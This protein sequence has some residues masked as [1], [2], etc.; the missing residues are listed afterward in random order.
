MQ[1]DEWWLSPPPKPVDETPT[2]EAAYWQLGVL[3]AL[4]AAGDVLMWGVVPGLSLTV[5]AGLC[6]VA[7]MLAWPHKLSRR[8]VFLSS[9]IAVLSILPIV[10]LVQ[11]LS[12]MILMTGLPISLAVLAGRPASGSVRFWWTAPLFSIRD[13]LH[14]IAA[15]NSRS[16]PLKDGDGWGRHLALGWGLPLGV[17]LVFAVLLISANPIL[18]DFIRNMSRSVMELPDAL[19]MLLWSVMACLIWPVLSLSRYARLMAP[20]AKSPK[21]GPRQISRFVNAKSVT[22]SLVLFNL[23]FGVQNALDLS[24]LSGG[25]GLPDGMTFAQYAHQGAYPL[26]VLALL[27]GSFALLSRPFITAAPVLRALL[28]IWVGQTILLTF[29][30]M[31]RL[32]AYVEVYGLTRLR[33]AAAIWM[34]LVLSGLGLTLWQI[35]YGQSNIWLLHRA[36]IMGAITVYASS[37]LSFDASIARYNLTKNLPRD[38]PYI[39]SLGEAATPVIL[40]LNSTYCWSR[41]PVFEPNDWREWGFRNARTR[42]KMTQLTTEAAAR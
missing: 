28:L 31:L 37:F 10:E 16:N 26:V 7:A 1:Q 2:H 42:H 4:I 27:S 36:A 6:I 19:R 29:S 3:A 20:S 13:A 18:D 39:C 5:F 30:S 25:A 40:D 41:D 17:G 8:T 38:S 22:R 23:M 35:A 15:F 33:I 21:Q 34:G 32:E 12:I 24:V 9:G 14:S 11:P